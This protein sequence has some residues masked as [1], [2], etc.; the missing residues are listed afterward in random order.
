MSGLLAGTIPLAGTISL[1]RELVGQ[2]SAANVDSVRVSHCTIAALS[3]RRVRIAG[4]LS[5]YLCYNCVHQL[6]LVWRP[7]LLHLNYLNHRVHGFVTNFVMSDPGSLFLIHI[8]SCTQ[9]GLKT[10]P[11]LQSLE[12]SGASFFS[13]SRHFFPDINCNSQ[14]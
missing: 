13:E 1:L 14:D 7:I 5:A 3:V 11:A 2:C 8:S 10:Y 9:T 6:R 4:Q 12:T